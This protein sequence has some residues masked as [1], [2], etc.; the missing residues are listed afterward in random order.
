MTMFTNSGDSYI[1]TEGRDSMLDTLPVG[2]Y[3]VSQSMSGLFYTRVAPFS[4]PGKLYGDIDKKANRILN[5]FK[6]RPN[7]TGVL[8]EGDK[9][10]G[11][12]QLARLVALKGYADNMPT[13][14][15]NAPYHGDQFN[16]LLAAVEEPAIVVM[17]E[18]EKVYQREVQEQVLTLLDGTLNSKKLF[19]L[20][21]NEKFKID[22][23][24][25]NRPG[26]IFYSLSYKGLDG[27]FVREYCQDNL[28]NQDH[29]ETVV[30]IG[31][32]FES[33][34]FDILKALVEE[35]NRYAED[36]YEAMEMLNAQPVQF[37]DYTKFELRV[38]NPE[39]VEFKPN[40]GEWGEH[41]LTTRHGVVGMWVEPVEGDMFDD[42]D[43]DGENP[44]EKVQAMLQA[45]RGRRLEG[46]DQVFRAQEMT[47]MDAEHG[48]YEYTN[49]AGWR[50]V[51]TKKTAKMTD[52]RNFIA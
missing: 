19:I 11:K 18:F 51:F 17:D 30:K 52:L 25:F 38:W 14:L 35:M 37:S 48:V 28:E 49:E 41:P 33:F 4:T 20:T 32:V 5:T 3:V 34:N 40:D 2:N 29:T 42:L 39:G 45:T 6:D 47:K 43:L 23:N 1:P 24:M 8:L 36:P 13:I 50:A 10:S 21:V 9:G 31:Q 26:R 22:Q 15:V 44:A 7:A 12:S 27:D 46:S 16:Q